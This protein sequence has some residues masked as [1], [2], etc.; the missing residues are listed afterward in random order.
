[1]C[2]ARLRARPQLRI[3]RQQTTCHSAAAT[4]PSARK[5]SAD[6][7]RHRRLLTTLIH[8]GTARYAVAP[9]LLSNVFPPRNSCFA[10]RLNQTGAQHEALFQ[11]SPA[12]RTPARM[13]IPCLISTEMPGQL[14]VQPTPHALWPPFPAPSHLQNATSY[15]SPLL[16]QISAPDQTDSKY[17]GFHEGG[18]LQ[19]AVSEALF[20]SYHSSTIAEGA[21]D[22]ALRPP[23]TNLRTRRLARPSRWTR[24]RYPPVSAPRS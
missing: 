12:E 20:D 9:C 3:P 1:M 19:V 17:M 22:T 13:Q 24:I 8:S 11:S 6:S 4:L 7:R 5:L 16:P 14:S 10:L 2:A 23:G 21:S 15:L 18:F